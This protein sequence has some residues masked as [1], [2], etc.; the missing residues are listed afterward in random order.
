METVRARVF[1]FVL[2]VLAALAWNL[3]VTHVF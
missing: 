3:H 2:L 1:W